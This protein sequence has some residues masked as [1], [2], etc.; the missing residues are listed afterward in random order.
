MF[1][2]CSLFLLFSEIIFLPYSV[3]VYCS[4]GSRT[5]F[6]LSI[7]LNEIWIQKCN[8]VFEFGG[9]N[10]YDLIT[11]LS[12]LGSFFR[13]NE[14]WIRKCNVVF[15][16]GCLNIYDLVH[17]FLARLNTRWFKL[18]ISQGNVSFIWLS[19]KAK[20]TWGKTGQNWWG[21]GFFA[22]P[23]G[24]VQPHDVCR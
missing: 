2:Y 21:G 6:I 3:L 24:A 22:L 10:I 18:C 17:F 16:F 13:L 7:R 20:K 15:E 19:E 12:V 5:F 1:V 23:N 4:L 8:V 14:I 9:P 11:V